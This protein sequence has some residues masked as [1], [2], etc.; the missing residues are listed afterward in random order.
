MFLRCPVLLCTFA[1]ATL[2]RCTPLEHL[3]IVCSSVLL[4]PGGVVD[5]ASDL[6]AGDPGYIPGRFILQTLKW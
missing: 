1:H 5:S 3:S 2:N 6:R 4:G